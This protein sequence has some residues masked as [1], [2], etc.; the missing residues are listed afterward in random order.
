[1]ELYGIENAANKEDKDGQGMAGSELQKLP[2]KFGCGLVKPSESAELKLG[3]GEGQVG[4][5]EEEGKSDWQ[6]ENIGGM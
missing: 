2:K 1:M 4:E 3:V 5:I 6:K